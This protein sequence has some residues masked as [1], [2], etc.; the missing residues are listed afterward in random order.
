MP[1][2]PNNLQQAQSLASQWWEW[3]VENY[4]TPNGVMFF[5]ICFLVFFLFGKAIGKFLNESWMSI[6]AYVNRPAT[7]AV[8][9]VQV[10]DEHGKPLML[11]TAP[12]IETKNKD[13]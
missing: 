6:K 2:F 10:I 3:I 1:P 7:P 9:N 4:N 11:Q 5:T 13:N 8:I 12:A